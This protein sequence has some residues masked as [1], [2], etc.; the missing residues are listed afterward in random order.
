MTLQGKSYHF[1]GSH[2]M[3]LK[4]FELTSDDYAI[5]VEDVIT[6]GGTTLKTIAAIEATGARVYPKIFTWMNRSGMTHLN[7]CEIRNN[8]V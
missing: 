6:T 7:G 5:V 2:D 1:E 3:A 4:R 8:F